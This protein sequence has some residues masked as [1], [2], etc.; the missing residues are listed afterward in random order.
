MRA[1]LARAAPGLRCAQIAE[2]RRDFLDIDA[3]LITGRYTHTRLLELAE[4]ADAGFYRRI[5][6]DLF[7]FLERYP[8]RRFAAYGTHPAHI[9]AMPERF[10]QWRERII[11]DQA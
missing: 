9:G 11:A 4:Q 8:D 3:A 7:K 6:A 1:H 2:Q 5:F 10:A